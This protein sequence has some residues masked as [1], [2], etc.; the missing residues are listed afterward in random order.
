MAKGELCRKEVVLRVLT[1]RGEI[2]DIGS[3]GIFFIAAVRDVEFRGTGRIGCFFG[4]ET[5]LDPVIVVWQCVLVAPSKIRIALGHVG[6]ETRIGLDIEID[7]GRIAK[8]FLKD[9]VNV[10]IDGF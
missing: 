6:L 9:E 10:K 4:I 5:T 2:E 7:V 3:I 1:E 8:W